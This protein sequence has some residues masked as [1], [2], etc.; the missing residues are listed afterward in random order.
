MK[1]KRLLIS[2][3][4][5]LTLLITFDASQAQN[6]KRRQLKLYDS[7]GKFDFSWGVPTE[8]AQQ[9]KLKLIDFLSTKLSQKK[10]ARVEAT[11][12]FT[13]HG[14]IVIS[15]FYIEPKQNGR[16]IIFER[17]KSFCCVTQLLQNRKMKPRIER[18]TEV[19]ET[20]SSFETV[21]NERLRFRGL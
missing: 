3:F 14:D 12:P 4:T 20:F 13:L 16:W 18:G 2:F 5:I 17:W 6:M 10:L 7:G 8:E 21:I 19:F 1:E 11:I 15:T 9:N